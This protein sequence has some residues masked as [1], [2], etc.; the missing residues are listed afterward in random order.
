M[1]NSPLALVV[2]VFGERGEREVIG[3]KS[4]VLTLLDS[5]SRIAMH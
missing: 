5:K 2:K 4:L 1:Y 3:N